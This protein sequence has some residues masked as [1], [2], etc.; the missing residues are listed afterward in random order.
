M[1]HYKVGLWLFAASA[2]ALLA[3]FVSVN[4]KSP[5]GWLADEPLMFL[6]YFLTLWTFVTGLLGILSGWPSL[7]RRFPATTRPSGTKMMGQVLSV[8]FVPEHNITGLVVGDG[9]LYLWTLWPFAIL[10]PALLI[11]WTAIEDIR[12]QRVLFWKRYALQAGDTSRIVVSRKA[13][14]AFVPHVPTAR[15]V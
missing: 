10:R 14:E 12:E 8:G 15:R 11:P 13:Y 7:A 1:T 2:A 4:G 3:F 5:P 9:G 6:A